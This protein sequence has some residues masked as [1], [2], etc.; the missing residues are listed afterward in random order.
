M[1]FRSATIDNHIWLVLAVSIKK[2]ECAINPKRVAVTVDPA[3]SCGVIRRLNGTNLGP[4]LLFEGIGMDITDDLKPLQIPLMRLH[5]APWE[6]GGLKLVDIPQVFPLFHADPADPRNYCFKQT[7]DYIGKCLA[8]GAKV[9]YRLGISIE[10]T[11]R[12]YNTEPPA[13]FDK[14]AEICC[15]IIAHY[16]E[17]WGDGFR[18]GIEYWEIWNEA[19]GGALMWS[20]TWDDYIRLYITAAKAIKK[21]F[22]S[23]KVG[24]PAIC[25][26]NSREKIEAFLAACQRE[27][28][29]L[30]FFSWHHYTTDA[31]DM[32]SKA[33]LVKGHLD[34]YGFGKTELHLNEWHYAGSFGNLFKSRGEERR[35]AEVLGMNEIGRA[36]V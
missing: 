3:Q 15:R 25:S 36:H 14:W 33:A 2:G 8:T 29:P 9:L 21:R 22:P 19:D 18:H 32:A 1:L 6:N 4:P 34:A 13:D 7:D 11:K 30:D 35:Q 12:K 26:A 5:D 27:Q 20:G 17:G 10:H 28:A 24:G 23:V 31:A 16:N